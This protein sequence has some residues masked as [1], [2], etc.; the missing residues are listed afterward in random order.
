MSVV[1]FVSAFTN[2]V[3]EPMV[4][5]AV[6]LLLHVPPPV[7]SVSVVVLPAHNELRPDMADSGFTVSTTVAKHPPGTV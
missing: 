7:A 2:P 6:L 1:P 5:T 3:D 4:A